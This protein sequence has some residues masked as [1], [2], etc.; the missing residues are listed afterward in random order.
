MR[1]AL[2]QLSASTDPSANRAAVRR[3]LGAAATASP[4]L[5][6]LPEAVM[7][8]FGAGDLDLAAVAEPLDGPFVALL[9]DLASTHR[10][11]VVAGMFERVGTGLPANT[12]VVVGPEGDL[13]ATYRKVH[14]YDAFGHR[15]SDRLTAGEPVAVTVEVAGVRVGLQTCY[16]LR[17]PELSRALVDAGAELLV[18]PSAWVRGPL[19]ER[20]WETLLAARAIEST[21]WVAA[22]AQNGQT[23]CGRSALVDPMGVVVAAL[24][25]QDGVVAGEVDPTRTA[26]V[27]RR[28]P[29]LQHRRFR[30]VPR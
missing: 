26:E 16:D 11:T 20:H 17:F 5:V 19:K 27:R 7:C 21:A 28:N 12:L 24:G 23:Y 13:L 3:A 4:D 18:V 8:D 14:L 29:A 6:V 9:A 15:E 2:C 25:E 30:V 1:I 22:A 10:T